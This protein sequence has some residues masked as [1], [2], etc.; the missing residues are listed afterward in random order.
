MAL[1]K[2]FNWI[3]VLLILLGLRILWVSLKAGFI[4]E[5][6]KLLATVVSVYLSLHYYISLANFIRKVAGIDFIP[7]DLFS[8]FWFCF[9]AITGYMLVSFLKEFISRL[10]KAEAVENVNRWGGFV[11]GFLRAYLICG[12]MLFIMVVSGVAYFK[13]SIKNSYSGRFFIRAPIVTY[14]GLWYGTISKFLV[15][16]KY[17]S[18]IEKIEEDIIK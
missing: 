12:F 11:L 2:Q 17:N 14:R 9:L 6:F 7:E 8:F 5:F 4:V 1:I 10:F 18:V 13:T 15:E 16:E 3:D